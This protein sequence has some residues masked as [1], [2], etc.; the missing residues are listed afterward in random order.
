[1]EK[2]REKI[3]IIGAS[4]AGLAFAKKMIA[5][6]PDIELIIIDKEKMPTIFPMV[7]I[8]YFENKFPT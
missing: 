3:H 1:M 5:L 7:L 8:F 2:I 4:F 6:K